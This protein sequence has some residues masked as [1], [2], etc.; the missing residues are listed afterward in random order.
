MKQ[1][2]NFTTTLLIITSILFLLGL[3]FLWL[4]STYDKINNNFVQET[5]ALFRSTIVAMHDS[6]MLQNIQVVPDSSIAK[7][8]LK[9][10]LIQDSIHFPAHN[11]N[12]DKMHD[13]NI[14]E[15][16]THITHVDVILSGNNDSI[17]KGMLKPLVN[18]I[19]KEKHSKTFII[20]LGADSLKT[21]S[22][23][24]YFNQTLLHAEINVPFTINV[25]HREEGLNNNI[26]ASPHKFTSEVV[27]LNPTGS[28]SVTFSEVE[29]LLIKQIMPQ[30][31]FCIFLSLITIGAFFIMH[32]NLQSQQKLMDL[33]NEFIS[34]I[35]HE[36]Q[37]PVAT[38]SV[39][40]EALTNFN[41][42]GDNQ[43]TTEYL[44]IAQNELNR[45]SLMTDKIL[46]NIV[47]EHKK[48]IQLKIEKIDL[49]Y[50]IQN[51]LSSMKV[52]FE[53]RSVK[54]SFERAG[55]DFNLEG[56][57]EHITNIVHNLID[58][59]IKYSTEEPK[60]TIRLK[61][62]GHHLVLSVQDAGI[63]IPQEYQKKIFEKFFRIPSAN[64]HNTKGYG[65]GLHYV[66]NII[67]R[68]N[69][70]IRVESKPGQGSC[71][72]ITFPKQLK[73]LK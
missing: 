42:L 36:L 73:N 32:R 51:V 17:E 62:H 5:N 60:I 40:L 30:I 14:H 45:L 9:R 24:K 43:K 57:E 35:T 27:S 28:Y 68:H 13:T 58:N 70:N 48:N 21:D 46:A 41:A 22:I 31:L 18:R 29:V 54:L 15:K 3:Q 55:I 53:K 20:K 47:L 56:S 49:D 6:L 59:A 11:A 26:H 39:A 72:S 33:K 8:E 61:D 69:A 12:K 66:A 34:N 16:Q 19:Q 52:V 63:G 38:V 44:N 67:K 65:L 50:L 25:H 10:V 23:K 37:T 7:P 4:R 2:R 1:S 64:V 71:F